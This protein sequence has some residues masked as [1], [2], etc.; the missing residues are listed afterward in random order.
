VFLLTLLSLDPAQRGNLDLVG[1]IG[2]GEAFH[3]AAIQVCD[4]QREA[5]VRI[6]AVLAAARLGL[7]R[8]TP[9]RR[10]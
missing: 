3:N 7:R 6:A 1:I 8:L 2:V 9:G 5:R 10:D 4:T